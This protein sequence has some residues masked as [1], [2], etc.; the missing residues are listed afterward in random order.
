MLKDLQEARSAGGHR[1]RTSLAEA[2][3]MTGSLP[4]KLNHLAFAADAVT[5][6]RDG[7]PTEHACDAEPCAL[8]AGLRQQ[9]VGDRAQG[10]H[11]T[12]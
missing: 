1:L 5:V 4:A 3:T 12:E 8:E 9:R 2:Y 6:A 11:V 7:A 10:R